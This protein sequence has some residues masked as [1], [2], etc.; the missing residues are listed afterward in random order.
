MASHDELEGSRHCT[1]GGTDYQTFA[2]LRSEE[3]GGRGSHRE[4]GLA[5]RD[6]TDSA[7]ATFGGII[8]RAGKEGA[9]AG[10]LKPGADNRQK[11]LAE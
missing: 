1:K 8:E 11:I 4:R 7:I 6:H 9:S 5:G 2:D 10:S 3:F